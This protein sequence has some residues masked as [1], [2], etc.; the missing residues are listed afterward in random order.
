MHSVCCPTVFP[1]CASTSNKT[2]NPAHLSLR[3]AARQCG[4]NGCER[5]QAVCGDVSW[6]DG[7]PL[8]RTSRGRA[9]VDMSH[10]H[11]WQTQT[12][13][14][15]FEGSLRFGWN[16]EGQWQRS[17]G[18]R[19]LPRKG[20]GNS[21]IGG[22][23]KGLIPPGH[24]FNAR[25]TQV[26]PSLGKRKTEVGWNDKEGNGK[27]YL[28]LIKQKNWKNIRKK[29]AF[30]TF[31]WELSWCL[32]TWGKNI[33]WA[34]SQKM[35]RWQCVQRGLDR[36]QN[37]KTKK[38]SENSAYSSSAAQ[39]VGCNRL[40]TRT[41]QRLRFGQKAGDSARISS[42]R[43]MHLQHLTAIIMLCFCFV[44]L[45]LFFFYYSS[46]SHAHPAC[47]LPLT[48]QQ[49]STEWN[50]KE[51]TRSSKRSAQ[52]PQTRRS[53]HDGLIWS[54]CAGWRIVHQVLITPVWHLCPPSGSDECQARAHI[55]GGEQ[56]TSLQ[57]ALCDCHT[58]FEKLDGSTERSWP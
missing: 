16:P 33:L 43:S 23:V 42:G 9:A 29:R 6:T 20:A 41:E 57:R 15:G 38:N 45:L 52:S 4:N 50:G 53:G 35:K 40:A 2:T 54:V 39:P 5:A 8:A 13:Q 36:K 7:E 21:G 44:I 27:Q 25:E 31:A 17:E 32:C 22:R 18:R 3:C 48:K 14:T 46:V 19:W 55:G 28:Y 30:E 49:R 51:E 24:W 58:T 37:E 1:C 10:R 12:T 34:E 11:T 56:G 26:Q 47:C